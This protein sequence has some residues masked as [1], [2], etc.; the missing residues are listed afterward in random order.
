MRRLVHTDCVTRSQLATMNSQTGSRGFSARYDLYQLVCVI[1]A[2]LGGMSQ[3]MAMIL[4]GYV[5]V[6]YRETCEY[7]GHAI[8][9]LCFAIQLGLM[10]WMRSDKVA[11]GVVMDKMAHSLTAVGA[12][13]DKGMIKKQGK[14]L[15]AHGYLNLLGMAQ[16]HLDEIDQQQPEP[17]DTD[18]LLGD[19]DADTQ[20]KLNGKYVMMRSG[21]GQT[22]PLRLM[23]DFVKAVFTA[24]FR[25]DDPTLTVKDDTVLPMSLFN[26][27][28][29]GAVI[30]KYNPFYIYVVWGVRQSGIWYVVKGIAIPM[31]TYVQN[32]ALK[33]AEAGRPHFAFKDAPWINDTSKITPVP[34]PKK[35]PVVTVPSQVFNLYPNIHTDHTFIPDS[36]PPYPVAASPV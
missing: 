1:L 36:P 7:V 29:T 30:E 23:S 5:P 6:Q 27:P 31:P 33:R 3:V 28:M 32:W 21:A 26:Q 24:D 17:E 11:I 18:S 9:I 15:D 19:D 12:V 8:A 13:G 2:T 14:R 16:Q 4:A 34:D 20:V 35:V 22:L 25:S 10:R